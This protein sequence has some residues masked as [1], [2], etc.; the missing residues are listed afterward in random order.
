MAARVI[1][2]S[3]EYCNY[4][5]DQDDSLDGTIHDLQSASKAVVVDI[6]QDIEADMVPVEVEEDA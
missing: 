2:H 1:Q 4:L 5:I 6:E 3:W